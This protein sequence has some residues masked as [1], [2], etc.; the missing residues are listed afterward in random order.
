MNS[1]LKNII[2][3]SEDSNTFNRMLSILRGHYRTIIASDFDLWNKIKDY[4]PFVIFLDNVY[5]GKKGNLDILKT[6]KQKNPDLPVVMI[7]SSS[8]NDTTS[9]IEAMKMGAVDYITKPIAS[10]IL[11]DMLQKLLHSSENII[12]EKV[13][14]VDDSLLILEIIKNTLKE[15]GFAIETLSNANTIMEHISESTPDI[16]LLDDI[17]PKIRGVDVCK[18]LKK[19]RET[20]SIPIIMLTGHSDI[21]SRVEALNIG[22]D[23]YLVKP[24]YD[25]ELVARVRA[26]LR[27]K[28]LQKKVAEANKMII[29]RNVR[30]NNDLMKANQ[31]L[32][33]RVFQLS[34]LHN[35]GQSLSYILNIDQLISLIHKQISKVVPYD[36]F[37]LGLYDEDTNYLSIKINWNQEKD[38]F[39]EDIFLEES[40]IKYIIDTKKAVL[41]GTQ[42][43][44]KWFLFPKLFGIYEKT[45]ESYI[46]IPLIARNKVIGVIVIQSYETNNFDDDSL[47]M[48]LTIGNQVAIAIANSQLYENTLKARDEEQHIRNIFQKYVPTEVVTQVLK[49]T[50]EQMLIGDKR[51]VTLLFCD[52]R[53]FTAMSENMSPANVVN[54]LNDYFTEMVEII[55]SEGGILDKFV[56]DCLVALFGAPVSYQ[57]DTM[58]A[59]R[60]ALKMQEKL[61]KF[62]EKQRKN[63]KAEIHNG[64]GI[65]T[66]EAIIGNIGST[67]RMDYTAVGDVVG[68]ASEIERLT[69]SKPDT[70]LIG[71]NIYN[72]IE[73]SVMVEKW[74]PIFFKKQNQTLQVYELLGLQEI[75]INS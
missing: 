72:E 41:F 23:D 70:I 42:K 6:I 40:I 45:T 11:Y 36:C 47:Q 55:S 62:N 58:R 24:F 18:Q 20:L 69:K 65:E 35:I 28:D 22:A 64:I 54:L 4:K 38:Y 52:I 56:G 39:V 21:E 9:T 75:P 8:D 14:V 10:N 34:T 30:L 3:I 53:N 49:N 15:E 19:N 48:L 25:K 71:E 50:D 67:A 17:M 16:I 32:K 63:G 68:I 2:I 43:E 57:D 73:D 66:G 60:R 61:K 1:T 59:I 37:L 44:Q 29:G 5:F 33:K 27:I 31:S 74:K 13:L 12:K 51:I 26:L 46:A 7:I